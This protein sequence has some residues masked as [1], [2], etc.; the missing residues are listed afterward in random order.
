M[1]IST[2]LKELYAS[3]GNDVILHTLSFNHNTWASPYYIVKDWQDLTAN[4]H[5]GGPSITFNKYAFDIQG[6][7]VDTKGAKYLSIT[8][9]NVSRELMGLLE[10]AIT[11]EN[12]VAIEVVYRIYIASDTS[13]PQNTPAL[14][15]NLR[16]VRVNN[17]RI[18]GIAEISSAL[19]MKFPN[20]LYDSRFKSLLK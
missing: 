12:F 4:L 2:E 15:L 16:K 14:Y 1:A 3:G 9:D 13:Q 19:N 17:T 8:L 18:T 7:N 6:P 11:D 5:A 20:V 10:L